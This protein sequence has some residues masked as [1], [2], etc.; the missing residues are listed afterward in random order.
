M[1]VPL[2][3][4]GYMVVDIQGAT[5]LA[6]ATLVDSSKQAKELEDKV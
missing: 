6:P 1:T 5:R 2:T 3:Y 4:L